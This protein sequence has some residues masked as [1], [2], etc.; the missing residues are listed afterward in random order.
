MRKKNKKNLPSEK[1]RKQSDSQKIITARIFFFLNAVLWLAY[2]VYVYYD[3]A[4]ANNNKSSADVATLFVFVNA[5]LLL[6]SGIKFGK[7]QKWTYYFALG[8]AV[9][10]AIYTISTL[11][12]IFD[13][14][15]FVF[16]VL[17][18]FTLLA[19][20]PL[21]KRYPLNL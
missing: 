10:N 13:L 8:V 12:N 2:G 16:F 20:L 1:N 9:F 7:P 19:I 6:F 15:F 14:Y 21:Y 5:G 4:V 18:L 3:M 17:S 11:L